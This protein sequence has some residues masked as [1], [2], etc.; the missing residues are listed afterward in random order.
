[1]RLSGL[2]GEAWVPLTFV[3]TD[4]TMVTAL[5]GKDSLAVNEAPYCLLT[6][7]ANQLLV[8]KREHLPITTSGSVSPV[9]LPPP[10]HHPSTLDFQSQDWF[11]DLDSGFLTHSHLLSNP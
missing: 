1:M 11:L 8:G 6:G 10:S 7:T 3:G 2:V 4:P 9:D 5:S